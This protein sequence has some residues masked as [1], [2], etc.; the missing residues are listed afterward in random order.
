MIGCR[1]GLAILPACGEKGLTRT[2]PQRAHAALNVR[3]RLISGSIC[4]R[5][6]SFPP[7]TDE[8]MALARG[9]ADTRAFATGSTSVR[10]AFEPRKQTGIRSRAAIAF[11]LRQFGALLQT[12]RGIM[13]FGAI[14]FRRNVRH[15]KRLLAVNARSKHGQWRFPGMLVTGKPI[16]L[17]LI[18][19][20]WQLA[21]SKTSLW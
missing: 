8:D 18:G 10:A 1:I 16:A 19:Q 13:E 2:G 6:L 4:M 9:G 20:V 21:L 5:H 11:R 14:G 17:T 3:N 7:R 15:Q 12:A